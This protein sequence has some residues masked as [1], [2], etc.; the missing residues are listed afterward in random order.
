M[1]TTMI[2]VMTMIGM[3]MIRLYN[4]K[5]EYINR[6]YFIELVPTLFNEYIVIREYG[7]KKNKK[8]TRVLKDY[9]KA[10]SEA[11]DFI[12]NIVIKKR[13]RGYHE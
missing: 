1:M 13:K 10:K 11:L 9:F 7:S 8:P 2:V 5:K 3:M 12:L 6:Y 4:I